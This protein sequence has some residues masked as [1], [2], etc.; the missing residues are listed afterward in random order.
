M[1]RNAHIEDVEIIRDLINEY[2]E[3][4]RMLFRSLSD[5]YASLHDF[6]VCAE[7]GRVVGCCA[8]QIYW[9]DLAE[10]KS[11]AVEEKFQGKGYGKAM[12]RSAIEHCRELQ[13]PRLFTL[14][15][16]A[17]FFA[18]LGFEKVPMNSLPFKVWSDCVRCP[19][20][21]NCDEIAMVLTMK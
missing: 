8:V 14:T 6:M 10:V 5:L 16:E 20:Q 2:A 18:K 13:I 17:E 21:D 15:L 11:L 7:D 19:K 1:I 12:V 9:K 4:S 3:Q